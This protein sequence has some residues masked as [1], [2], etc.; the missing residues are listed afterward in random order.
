[1][2]QIFRGGQRDARPFRGVRGVRHH[3]ALERLDERDTWVFAPAAA[4]RALLV[5]GLGLE[6]DS[7]ALDA[8]RISR[9][10]EAH[11][12]DPDARVVAAPHQAR[13]EIELTVGAANGP[14]VEHPFALERIARLGLH[15]D[16]ESLHVKAAHR[17]SFCRRGFW[18]R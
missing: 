11:A 3:V 10:V 17:R 2:K 5:R 6:R 8:D 9:F 15:D 18:A 14:G 16:T 4:P 7:E 1:V 12:R 13:K